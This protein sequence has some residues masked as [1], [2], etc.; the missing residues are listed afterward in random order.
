MISRGNFR[1]ARP[2]GAGRLC[3]R[4]A[5]PWVA[6]V[7]A[8]CFMPIPVDLQEG[9][10]QE[11]SEAPPAEEPVPSIERPSEVPP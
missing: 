11:I 5:K 8:L 6:A 9:G 4:I 7:V 2:D 1:I 3:S 10:S